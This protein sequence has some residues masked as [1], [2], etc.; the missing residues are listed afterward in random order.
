LRLIDFKKALKAGVAD[1]IH[2][3]QA[4]VRLGLTLLC[5][6]MAFDKSPRVRKWPPLLGSK[7]REVLGPF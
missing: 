2:Q 7:R 1:V 3:A 5:P 6:S 4:V